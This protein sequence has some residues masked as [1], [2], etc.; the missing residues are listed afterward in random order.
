MV[1]FV[2]L[3]VK[4]KGMTVLRSFRLARIFKMARKLQSLRNIV[5][6]L[7]V[8]L[9]KIGSM[10]FLLLIYMFISSVAGMQLLGQVLPHEE[11][12]RFDGF[13]ISMLTI[14]QFLTGE[15]WN[16]AMYAGIYYSGSFMICI[17]FIIVIVIGLFIV[18]NLFLAILLSDFDAVRS[19][20]RTHKR[21]YAHTHVLHPSIPARFK[22]Y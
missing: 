12:A 5:E 19:N 15:N 8:T 20:T 4:V 18:L 22:V 10:F 9:P 11:R 6:S 3:T 13:A 7:L 21:T 2:E 16:E 1:S 17:Y 14:F